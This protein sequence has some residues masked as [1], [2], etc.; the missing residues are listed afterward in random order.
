LTGYL[1]L[2][3]FWRHRVVQNGS[4]K[5]Y[6]RE[7]ELYYVIYKPIV[8]SYLSFDHRSSSLDCVSASFI[9]TTYDPWHCDISFG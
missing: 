8:H 4:S 3:H 2:S 6:I 9:I 1:S 5:Y 7:V